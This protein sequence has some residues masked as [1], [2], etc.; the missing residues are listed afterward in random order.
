MGFI[1]WKKYGVYMQNSKN[2]TKIKNKTNNKK[3][4]DYQRKEH[5][6]K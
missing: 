1:E 5:K 6:M 4:T 3:I 2:P